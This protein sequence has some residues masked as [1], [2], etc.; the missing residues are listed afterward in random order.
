[1]IVVKVIVSVFSILAFLVCGCNA[2]NVK[3]GDERF[4]EVLIGICFAMLGI[5]IWR[6][7]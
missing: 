1:M 4:T 2:V 3:Y 6:I 5:L 7:K